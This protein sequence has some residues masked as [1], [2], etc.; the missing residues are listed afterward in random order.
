MKIKLL[1]FL[2]LSAL[3]NYAH[4]DDTIPVE[5]RGDYVPQ[6]DSCVQNVYMEQEN[7]NGFEIAASSMGWY[8][9][10]STLIKGTGKVIAPNQFQGKFR[11]EAPDFDEV[12]LKKFTL[13]KNGM[14]L[15]SGQG[16][17]KFTESYTK[18][19]VDD[20]KKAVRRLAGIIL[21]KPLVKGD[22][23]L[24]DRDWAI[25]VYKNYLG[26]PPY[27]ISPKSIQ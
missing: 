5:F 23:Q 7:V 16:K 22:A 13:T 2:V 9:M 25:Q 27:G 14:V 17:K 8:E 4:A 18:C 26:N 6:N 19:T 11:D 1:S 15:S 10:S 3:M 24:M 20:Y 21:K 12:V